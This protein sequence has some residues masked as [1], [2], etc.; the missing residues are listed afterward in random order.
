MLHQKIICIWGLK[1]GS[2]LILLFSVFSNSSWVRTFVIIIP[3]SIFR[4][5]LRTQKDVCYAVSFEV[6]SWKLHSQLLVLNVQFSPSQL[7]TA[8]VMVILFFFMFF[9][10][11]LCVNKHRDWNSAFRSRVTHN[12]V[13]LKLQRQKKLL[14]LFL[15]FQS[16]PDAW[17]QIWICRYT[18]GIDSVR[19]S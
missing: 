13:N 3:I 8:C 5:T 16:S 7:F 17:I 4:R 9:P 19:V 6:A 11:L 10:L 12:P 14:T 15:C 1:C 18:L 2:E